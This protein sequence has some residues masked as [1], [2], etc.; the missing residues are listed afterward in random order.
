M[1]ILCESQVTKTYFDIIGGFPPAEILNE[2]KDYKG[3]ERVCV[4]CTQLDSHHA[5]LG[6]SKSDLKR[7]LKEW[8]NF[9]RSN[10]KQIKA[11]HFNT[12]VSQELFDAACCQENLEELRFKWG[13]YSDL[14][15]LKNLCQLKFLYIGQGSSVQDITILGEM[16][17]LAVL[18]IEAFKKIEDFSPLASLD[19]LEQLVIV[20]PTLGRTPVSDLEFL[21]IMPNLRSVLVS[22]ITLRKKYTS[23]ELAGL[24]A[25]LP[26]LHDVG[27]CLYKL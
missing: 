6:H 11:L 25:A 19:N 23:E 24:R 4:A 20:G 3:E 14:S 1:R 17:N 10:T 9:F 16:K 7:I 18:H 5:Y 22:N 12:R 15:S 21:R 2:F 13:G 26:N 27:Q 8:L